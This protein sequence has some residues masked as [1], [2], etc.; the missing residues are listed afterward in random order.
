MALLLAVSHVRHASAYAVT[1]R[2]LVAFVERARAAAGFWGARQSDGAVSDG[3]VSAPALGEETTR[4]PDRRIA[5]VTSALKR[6]DGQP[7]LVAAAQQARER[8]P[9]DSLYGDPLSTAGSRAPDIVG[10]QIAALTAARPSVVRELGFGALQVWQ[11]LSEAQGRG[12]GDRDLT[13]MFT[14]VVDFSSWALE[15]GDADA[16]ELLRQVDRA[17]ES[18][19]TSHKGR[20]IKRLGD[21][22]MAVF[23]HP[24]DAVDAALEARATVTQVRVREHH[25]Q[26]RVGIHV[27]RPRKL[28]GDYFGVDVNVAARIAAAAGGGDVLV[29]EAIPVYLDARRTSVRRHRRLDAK[30]T[31]TDLRV[32]VA[33]PVSPSAE[34][35][36]RQA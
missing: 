31:P 13:I 35:S 4:E 26:L 32:Y 33:E 12:Y 20:V 15:V 17:L 34:S 2:S 30:G 36:P 29:S 3:A 28:G 6:L 7:K 23:E 5:G 9:G 1:K 16:L 10:R 22:V 18:S 8:L 27:G 14:D 11:A 25:P 19:I 21:G 24:Q